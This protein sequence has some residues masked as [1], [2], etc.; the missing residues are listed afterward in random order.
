MPDFTHKDF[1]ARALIAGTTLDDAA[2]RAVE[3]DRAR[4]ALAYLKTKIGNDAMRTLLAD[5]LERTKARNR[6]SVEASAGRWKWD[7]LELIVP[8]PGA[9]TFHAYFMT[10]MKDDRQPELRAGHPDH[11]MNVPLGPHAEVI[12]NVGQDDLPWFIRLDFTA[13]DAVFPAPWDPAYPAEH[14]LGAFI[15]DADGLQIGSAIH[16]MRDADDGLHVKLTI[17]LP[18]AAPDPL[19]VGHL[20]HFAVEFRNW[21]HGAM[22]HSIKPRAGGGQV[23]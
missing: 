15:H 23:Q 6:R 19:V 2:I 16:E 9:A 14:R 17:I 20:H 18:E 8:G 10:M 3:L 12:E 4:R 5:D 11:F 1:H 13:P 7:S 22:E 21:T